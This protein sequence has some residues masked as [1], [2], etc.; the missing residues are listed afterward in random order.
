MSNTENKLGSGNGSDASA[1]S[2]LAEASERVHDR[3]IARDNLHERSMRRCVD[4]F[5]ALTGHELTEDQGWLFMVFLNMARAQNGN[6]YEK[7]NYVDGAAYLAFSG[8]AVK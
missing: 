3:S 2:I 4:G 5:N 8:E 6:R 1:C 7:D